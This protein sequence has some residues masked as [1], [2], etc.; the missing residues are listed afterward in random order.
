MPRIPGIRRLFRFPL[1]ED[2]VPTDVDAEITFHVETRTRELIA[3]GLDPL[4]ARATAMREFGDVRE[5]RAELE[6]IGR[7]RVRHVHRVD[8]WSDLAQD[9]KYGF[10]SLINAPLFSLLAIATLALGIG[11]NAA[12]FSVLKSVLLDALPYTEPD[13]LVRIYAR[14]IDGSMERGPMAAATIADIAQRQRSFER[15]AAY[16]SG[17]NNA[18]LG[19]ESGSRI[20]TVGWVESNFFDTLGVSAARGRTFRKDDATSGQVP[21]TGG[22]TDPDTARGVI[23]THAAWQRLFAGDPGLLDR[24]VRL[25]GLPRT[26]IGILPPRFVGPL[27]DVDFYFSFDLAP[28]VSH[29]VMGR[30][31][32]W[33]GAIGRLK[34]GVSSEDAGRE[35]AG[36]GRDLA[37]EHPRDNSA[38]DVTA[39]PLRDWMVGDTRTPLLV[40]MT[41]AALVLLIACA[42]LTG[43]LLSRTLARRKELAVRVALGAGRGR[44]VRQLLTES[45]LLAMAGGAAG[46]GLAWLLLSAARR[47]AQTATMLPDYARLS[48]DGEVMLISALLALVTGLAFGT[49]PALSADRTDPQDVLRA[50]SR[51]ATEGRRASRLR[52]ALV[53]GQIA[54]CV[55]LLAGAGLLARSLWAMTTAPL[56]FDPDGVFTA[57]IMLPARQ[58]PK[59][60]DKVRFLEQ[61][62]ERLRALPGVQ[63]VAHVGEVPTRLGSRMSF[64]IDG[65]PRR[66]GDSDPFVLFAPVS[67]DYF[68]LL[69]IPLRQ[70]RTFD[71]RDREGAPMTVVISETMARR[72]WPRGEALG[73]RIRTGPN[74]KA[75]LIE[76]I[77]IVGDVRNDRARADAE[78]MLYRSHRQ[79]GWP[80]ASILL[81]TAGEPMTLLKPVE[82]ELASIDAGLAFERAATLRA[83]IGEG[84]ARRQVPVL[85]MTAF[86]ALALL[87]AS[88]GVYAMFASIAAAR[89]REFG[90]RMALGSRPRAIAGLL[91]RQGAGWMAAGLAGGVLGVG[92]VVR[93]LRGLLYEVPPFDPIALGAA[94][95]ILLC[96][97]ALA[98]LVPLRRATRVDPA[99]ALRE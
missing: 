63:G 87:L 17:V 4:A 14:W 66:S 51:G 13:R 39:M 9:L 18:V 50:E 78:P 60:A 43:A 57:S 28:V 33:L 83:S 75:P 86:G 47:F 62:T 64:S 3:K 55:S 90:V 1:S 35:L 77:G 93:L 42:N 30:A 12:V 97:A 94:V 85:L 80:L 89:E 46:V 16:S 8:W 24:D 15:I 70:G 81:R 44:L 68:R 41:S 19:E 67:D 27:G 53:A 88:I 98:L 99:V 65:A 76:V 61:F 10:R 79:A 45:V 23:V 6:T 11:A 37:R 2:R 48:L 29:P 82:R 71:V 54:L 92:L 73:A 5:A 56:G 38:F 95:A 26:V 74:P 36:I 84:I 91:L 32:Q 25:N 52:G 20:A 59:P 96:S 40:L 69:R 72:Y 34:P 22:Q 7:R 31:S 49:A 58:Y 21:L